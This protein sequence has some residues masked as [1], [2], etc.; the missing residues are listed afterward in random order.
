MILLSRVISL[1]I[2]VIRLGHCLNYLS[3]SVSMTTLDNLGLRKLIFVRLEL[4]LLLTL[5]IMFHRSR[6]IKLELNGSGEHILRLVRT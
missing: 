2:T 3:K 1:N 5:A 4:Y 6:G